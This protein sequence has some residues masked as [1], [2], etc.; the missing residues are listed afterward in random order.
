MTFLQQHRLGEQS[1]VTVLV[2]SAFC[3]CFLFLSCVAMACGYMFLL[4]WGIYI[5]DNNDSAKTNA[6]EDD[7]H[8]WT[9]AMLNE[10]VGASVTLCGCWEACRAYE[11]LKNEANS[12]DSGGGSATGPTTYLY[13]KYGTA[14]LVSFVFFLWGMIIWFNVS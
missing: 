8:V 12:D 3:C 2:A 14:I 10:I 6:C 7:Y 1:T 9:F 11:N 5:L 13:V 4:L